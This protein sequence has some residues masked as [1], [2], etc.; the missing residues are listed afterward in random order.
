MKIKITQSFLIPGFAP[1]SPGEL[2]DI[3]SKTAHAFV[4]SGFAVLLE[5]REREK[6]TRSQR[7][8]ATRD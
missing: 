4:K 8:T 1:F 3:D 5:K 2:L 6:A 7:E